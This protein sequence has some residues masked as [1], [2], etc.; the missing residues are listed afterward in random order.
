MY[1]YR[2]FEKLREELKLELT[3]ECN[4]TMK[5]TGKTVLFSHF[6]LDGS[7]D[8]ENVQKHHKIERLFIIITYCIKTNP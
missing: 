7:N 8:V 2:V 1:S 4:E 5:Y 3:E 6:F